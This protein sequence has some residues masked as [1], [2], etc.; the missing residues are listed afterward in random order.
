MKKNEAL[1]YL[2]RLLSQ[3]DY[4][5]SDLRAKL[6]KRKCSPEIIDECINYLEEISLID[7]REYIKTFID[8]SIKKLEGP[9]KIKNKL[10]FKKANEEDVTNLLFELYNYETER[11]NI[12]RLFTR[13]K[14]NY[15]DLIDVKNKNKV[16]S[17]FLRK[18]YN[19]DLILDKINSILRQF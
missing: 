12:D 18:G 9:K 4:L 7:D 6:V 10:I 17:Y 13:K 14:I 19:M 11:K 3:R 2:Y 1:K 15:N 16:I 8:F 5:S